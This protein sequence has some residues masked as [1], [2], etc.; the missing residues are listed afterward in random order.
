MPE[1][2]DQLT[3]LVARFT[4][5]RDE[6]LTS[7]EECHRRVADLV[8][9]LSTLE[10]APPAER[11]PAGV[12]TTGLHAAVAE[13]RAQVAA[14][15]DER[16]CLATETTTPFEP[17]ELLE[18]RLAALEAE[19]E[20][21]QRQL[22]RIGE[23]EG[24][25]EAMMEQWERMSA[26]LGA[27]DRDPEMALLRQRIEALAAGLA[28]VAEGLEDL[29]AVRAS[30]VD[31][32]RRIDA[33]AAAPAAAPAP[34]GVSD[35]LE[36]LRVD[37]EALRGEVARGSRGDAT[38]ALSAGLAEMRHAVAG[39]KQ[40]MAALDASIAAGL[41]TTAA[42]WDGEARVLAGRIDDVSRLFAAHVETHRRSF[43]ER[44]TRWA[45]IAGTMVATEVRWLGRRASAVSQLR[46]WLP[47]WPAS[48]W[49]PAVLPRLLPHTF[50]RR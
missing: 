42:R 40:Q 4:A 39:L 15:A 13:L 45:R 12:D 6:L 9:R 8:A 14:L 28:R 19:I 34:D 41:R 7:V 43:Q 20:A 29:G 25:M 24:R 5:D 27:R 37:V 44:A 38:G 17:M 36:R 26:D 1:S 23:L 31:L 21:A 47:G 46:D 18:A 11:L 48:L 3:S 16:A 35:A 50:G 10:Q 33:L 2:T 32:Q 30:L 49:P 22:P